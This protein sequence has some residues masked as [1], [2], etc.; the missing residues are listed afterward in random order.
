VRRRLKDAGLHGR[1]STKKPLLRPQNRAKRLAW[2]NKHKNWTYDDWKNVLWTDESKFEIF[3]TKRRVYVRRRTGERYLSACV[4]PTVKHGGGSV[5]V[6]GCFGAEKVGDLHQ[7]QGI[8]NK[9]GYHLI[10]QKHTIPSGTR[11]IGPKFILQQDND[12]KHTSL[13]CK[14][15]LE[16][17]EKANIL[18]TMEWPPQSPD[19]NP[20][21]L[22][23][24]ELDRKVR[25]MQ[26]TSAKH[27]WECLQNAW[28]SIPQSCLSKLTERMVRVCRAV[29][30]AKG[31]YFPESKI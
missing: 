19:L 13:L 25:E 11:L 20:I 10:L 6:W 28:E 16:N 18:Q 26:P 27:L 8:L 2:A 1:I 31:G 14:H 22:L 15:Y 23:W 9:N 3:N 17:K 5:M 12:P 7:V 4:T 29:I 21:E 30:T 24:D